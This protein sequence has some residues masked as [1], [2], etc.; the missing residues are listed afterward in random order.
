MGTIFL[1]YSTHTLESASLALFVWL[2]KV[3]REGHYIKIFF[4]ILRP[5][6]FH[7]SLCGN[8]FFPCRML[9]ATVQDM[10]HWYTFIYSSGIFFTP[11]KVS[12]VATAMLQDA[13]AYHNNPKGGT[14]GATTTTPIY[15]NTGIN[16]LC[17][18]RDNIHIFIGSC[19]RKN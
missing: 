10:V 4:L 2:F 17:Q 6:L 7:P 5:P 11:M 19:S 16:S 3:G 13:W 8:F 15:N 9:V 14:E 12:N 1:V 18:A